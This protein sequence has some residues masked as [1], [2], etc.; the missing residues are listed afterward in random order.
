MTPT[1]S[2]SAVTAPGICDKD[3]P[4]MNIVL[5]KKY[6]CTNCLHLKKKGADHHCMVRFRRVQNGE[7]LSTVI[8]EPE[9]TWCPDMMTGGLRNGK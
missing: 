3:P 2:R 1:P 5:Q 9:K 8:A 6:F 4:L 7:S